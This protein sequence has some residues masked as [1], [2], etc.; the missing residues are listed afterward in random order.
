M[1]QPTPFSINI[2]Q[3]QLDD[4]KARLRNTRWP[5]KETVTDWSQGIPLAYTRELAE[6]WAEEYDW[7]AREALL[8][9]YPQ[10]TLPVNG[11]EIHFYHVRSP[12]ASARPLL[13][14]HGWPG[15]P[16]EFQKVIGPLTDPVA[17]GGKA[18]DAFHLVCPSLPGYGF[19]AKPEQPGWSV[20]STATAW[21]ALMQALG[22]DKYYAQGGDWGSMVTNQVAMQDPEHCMGIHK[23]LCLIPPPEHMMADITAE[24]QSALDALTFYDQWDSGYSKQQSTRPQTLAY[25]LADSPSGQ[26]AWIVEKF[27]QWMDCDGHPE[28]ILTRDEIIDDVMMYW[29]T[30]SAGSSAQMYWE[31]FTSIGMENPS[32]PVGLSMF[33][34]EIMRASKRWAEDY[35]SQLA[36]FNK[37]DKGGHFAAFEQPDVFVDDVRRCFAIIDNL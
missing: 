13:M 18:E 25:G 11:L 36:F 32:C 34:K 6:Y 35:F 26:L 4:L 20:H 3:Q 29:I 23:N 22:Y 19:S 7:R 2:P 37:H 27:Y 30:N 33:P 17:H 16:V 10:F 15:S 9:K 21:V 14:T 8:N 28:N 1:T 12:E 5:S 31:S 24:E